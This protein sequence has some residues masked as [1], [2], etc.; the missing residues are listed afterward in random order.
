MI[1]TWCLLVITQA[2]PMSKYQSVWRKYIQFLFVNYTSESGEKKAW[3]LCR[4]LELLLLWIVPLSLGH[5]TNCSHFVVPNNLAF[6]FQQDPHELSG[7]LSESHLSE[8]FKV[9]NNSFITV[10]LFNLLMMV[11]QLQLLFHS[12]GHHDGLPLSLSGIVKIIHVL[13]TKF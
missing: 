9:K 13:E 12:W 5:F 2:T 6:Q 4:F 11:G 7:A 10:C 1:D 3:E 8:I